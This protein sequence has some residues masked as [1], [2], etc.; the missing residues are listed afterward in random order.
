VLDPYEKQAFDGLVTRLEADDPRFLRRV[1]RLSRPR[2]RLRTT[3]AILLWTVAPVCIVV[4][5]WT[6]LIM[7]V[8][9]AA[10]GAWL[11]SQRN[12]LAKETFW[13]SSSDRRPGTT[14]T[15]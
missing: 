7:A 8:V 3:I 1:Y 5:G 12:D 11:M 15:L 9:A 10:Y 4:G 2:R 13:R 14:P 6:G